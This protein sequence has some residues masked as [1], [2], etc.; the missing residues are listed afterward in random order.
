MISTKALE[1]ILKIFNKL[2]NHKNKK[3]VKYALFS[4]LAP[5]A[6]DMLRPITILIPSKII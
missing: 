3:Q 6:G 2:Q 4:K 1:V 5:F